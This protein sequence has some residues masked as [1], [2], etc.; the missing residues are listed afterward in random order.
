MWSK[1]LQQL[2]LIMA[3]VEGCGQDMVKVGWDV[4]GIIVRVWCGV[5]RE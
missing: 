5:V 2:V 3:S 4:A 1:L